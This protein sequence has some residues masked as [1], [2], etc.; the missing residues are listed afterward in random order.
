M[1]AQYLKTQTP[2]ICTQ[3]AVSSVRVQVQGTFERVKVSEDSHHIYSLKILTLSQE[4]P[5][6]LL[7]PQLR[8]CLGKMRENISQYF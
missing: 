2:H 8:Q 4:R 6:G 1:A 3:S 5:K 7:S